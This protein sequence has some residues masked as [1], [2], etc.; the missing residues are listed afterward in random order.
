MT[1]DGDTRMTA[2]IKVKFNIKLLNI[3]DH[4]RNHHA[5]FEIDKT[6]LTCLNQRI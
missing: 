3:K 6:I 4:I 5:K 1:D 2:F